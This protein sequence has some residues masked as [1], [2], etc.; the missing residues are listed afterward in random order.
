MRIDLCVDT[1]IEAN[2][3]RQLDTIV[4]RSERVR[5]IDDSERGRPDRC[6][7]VFIPPRE[8]VE[9]HELDAVARDDRRRCG[10]GHARIGVCVAK[11][12]LPLIGHVALH[13]SLEAADL[14]LAGQDEETG[15]V[16]VRQ[17]NVGTLQV[18]DSGRPKKLRQSLPFNADFCALELLRSKDDGAA[19]QRAEL[20]TRSRQ[21][22][23]HVRRVERKILRRLH[24]HGALRRYE[25][26]KASAIDPGV[27]IGCP[28]IEAVVTRGSDNLE[29]AGDLDRIA[30][31][32]GLCRKPVLAVRIRRQMDEIDRTEIGRV[33]RIVDLGRGAVRKKPA[34]AKVDARLPTELRPES[35]RMEDGTGEGFVDPVGIIKEVI[36]V[37]GVLVSRAVE[38]SV[39]GIHRA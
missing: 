38:C 26:V 14:I 34:V 31:I 11:P 32:G 3:P 36:S 8:L 17:G 33:E 12:R 21:V 1:G 19:G 13:L 20:I 2:E 9:R 28:D 7:L 18:V 16:R 4:G 6:E 37:R 27:P 25:I 23:D 5:E 10:A 30:H 29:V 35:D 22:G 24:D 39:H 15:I